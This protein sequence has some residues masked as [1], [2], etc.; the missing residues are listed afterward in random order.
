V[1]LIEHEAGVHIP[2]DVVSILLVMLD[3]TTFPP[4]MTIYHDN[5]EVIRRICAD[6]TRAVD[7]ASVVLCIL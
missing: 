6:K 2:T 7:P 4:D 1:A 5:S 3:V